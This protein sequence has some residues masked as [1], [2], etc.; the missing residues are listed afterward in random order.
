MLFSTLTT[1]YINIETVKDDKSLWTQ[2][3]P[4]LAIRKS[5]LGSITWPENV[6]EDLER[7]ALLHQLTQ[8]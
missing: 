8:K 7:S 3:N 2:A 6:Q 4:L 1:P 5:L